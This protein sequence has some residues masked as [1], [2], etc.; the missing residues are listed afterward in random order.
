MLMNPCRQRRRLRHGLDDWENMCH[1]GAN[2]DASPE[3][4]DALLEQGWRP[5]AEGDGYSVGPR[6]G[7]HISAMC[8]AV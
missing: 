7:L 8:A 3:L 2:A 4:A 5:Y 1:H 6:T